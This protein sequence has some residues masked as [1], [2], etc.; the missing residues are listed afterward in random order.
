MKIAIVYKSITGNTKL[1]AEAIKEE[2]PKNQLVYFGEPK[3][4]EYYE[5]LFERIKTNINDSNKILGKFFCQ[6]KMPM[7]IRDR[8]VDLIKEHPDDKRL[9]VSVENFDKALTHPDKKD[10]QNVKKWIKEIL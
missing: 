2:I 3:A 7:Q 8:Y 6:G 9:K 10:I 1:L 4:E 5:K